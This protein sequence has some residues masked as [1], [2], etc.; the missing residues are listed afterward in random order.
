[1]NSAHSIPP[2]GR[3]TQHRGGAREEAL[4]PAEAGRR[5]VERLER[6]LHVRAVVR[7]DHVEP[8]LD[9][10][11][12]LEHVRH[13]Q[14]VAERL[15]HL[16]AGGGDPGVVQPVRRERVPGRAGLRLLVLVVREA[17]VDAAAVD[18]E[19]VAEVLVGHRGALDVPA[20]TTRAPRGRPGG[21]LR[22]GGLLPAL[23]EREVAR[24]ALAARVGVRGG[25][26]VVDLLPRQLAV[27]RPR[28]HVEVDV[29]GAVGG[30]IGV[31]PLDQRGDQLDH[32]RDVPRR[33]RLVRRS[34]DVERGVRLVELVA[35]LVGEVVPG[36]TLLGGLRQDLVVD[37][38]GVADER[39]VV[40]GHPQPALQDVEV[41]ARADVADVRLRLHREPAQVDARLPLL[42]GNEVTDSAGRCV[43]ELEGHAAI[44]VAARSPAGILSRR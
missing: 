9:R 24:V 43:I 5:L 35:H 31:A 19:G 13:Q 14:R 25:L 6:E 23:P 36:T 41:H 21:G 37:V 39:D 32:L 44:V 10:A 22:L 3:R 12:P 16:L 2:V 7:R 33:G 27:R 15:A 8:Q 40:P 1:M 28:Q 42:E 26:H 4:D 20:R 29:T 17:Q 34:R 18:V 38:G 30:R 11:H